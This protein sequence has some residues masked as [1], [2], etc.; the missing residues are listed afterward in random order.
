[1]LGWLIDLINIYEPFEE[2]DFFFSKDFEEGLDCNDINE[3]KTRSL[4][5]FYREGGDD[6]TPHVEGYKEFLEKEDNINDKEFESLNLLLED[7][8]RKY[9]SMNSVKEQVKIAEKHFVELC[10][11]KEKI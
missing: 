9:D 11:D 6:A 8:V 3:I 7:I 5:A 10:N 1:M 2:C 4:V